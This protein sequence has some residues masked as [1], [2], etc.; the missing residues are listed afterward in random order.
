[1]P[2]ILGDL[3]TTGLLL[4]QYV[5]GEEGSETFSL[6]LPATWTLIVAGTC[7]NGIAYHRYCRRFEEEYYPQYFNAGLKPRSNLNP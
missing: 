4:A 2:T 1:M 5:L 7:L 3:L 6:S